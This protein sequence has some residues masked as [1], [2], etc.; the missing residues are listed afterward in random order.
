LRILQTIVERILALVLISFF[1]FLGMALLCLEPVSTLTC[2]YVE[3]AQVDCR[4]QER[5]VGVIPVREIPIT[6]LKKAYVDLEYQTRED[7]DGKEYTVSIYKVLLVSASGEIGFGGTEE[8]ALFSGGTTKRINDFLNAPTDE[9]LTVWHAAWGGVLA[10]TLAGG[11][12]LGLSIF[13]LVMTVLD[14]LGLSQK[15]K[16]QMARFRRKVE[17]A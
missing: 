4:L 5:I 2:R 7:E 1:G 14:M 3:T 13:M 12:S 17:S 16:D 9:S 10:V 11:L 8:K 6:R 15:V